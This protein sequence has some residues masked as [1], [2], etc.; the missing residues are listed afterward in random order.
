MLLNQHLPIINFNLIIDDF[1]L[2]IKLW[3]STIIYTQCWSFFKKSV[4]D[5][6]DV[7]TE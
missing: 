1:N 5:L 3:N 6:I 2:I 4:K 7:G